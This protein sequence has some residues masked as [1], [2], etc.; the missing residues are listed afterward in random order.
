MRRHGCV[1]CGCW[2]DGSVTERFLNDPVLWVELAARPGRW[3]IHYN[4][5][6]HPGRFA[7]V[8]ADDNAIY[9]SRGDVTACSLEARYWLDGFL[10]GSEPDAERMFGPDIWESDGDDPRWVRW[11]A[12][13]DQFRRTGDWLSE[14]DWVDP[15]N[16]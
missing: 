16:Q 5:H 10:R 12:A 2:F 6:T 7:V 15:S 1:L 4:P 13:L 3:T 8:D 14:W 9:A 11:R